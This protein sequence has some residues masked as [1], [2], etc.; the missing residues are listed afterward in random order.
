MHWKPFTS[1]D[2]KVLPTQKEMT[3]AALAEVLRWAMGLGA[4][5][6]GCHF[7]NC[8]LDMIVR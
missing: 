3:L 1:S 7:L 8:A 6:L 5:M 2:D 4:F